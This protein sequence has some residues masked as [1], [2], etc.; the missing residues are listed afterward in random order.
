[1]A[2][3][4]RTTTVAASGAATTQQANRAAGFGGDFNTF[5]M[6]WPIPRWAPRAYGRG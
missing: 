6:L 3:A 1:M 2:D 4:I 5:L